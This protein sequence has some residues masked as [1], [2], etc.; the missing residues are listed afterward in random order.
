MSQT[1]PIGPNN[2]SGNINES[3][4]VGAFQKLNINRE[5]FLPIERCR[6]DGE[7]LT[8][9]KNANISDLKNQF[10]GV[11]I[12]VPD[13]QNI[14]RTKEQSVQNDL[15]SLIKSIQE[16]RKKP[17]T[18]GVVLSSEHLIGVDPGKT[19]RI[20][21]GVTIPVDGRFKINETEAARECY[22]QIIRAINKAGYREESVRQFEETKGFVGLCE[23]ANTVRLQNT[24]FKLPEKWWLAALFPLI[25]LPFCCNSCA[26]SGPDLKLFGQVVKDDF[27]I[28]LDKS[29]SM[30]RYFND[31]A[32]QAQ[33]LMNAKIKNGYNCSMDLITYDQGAKSVF[34]EITAIKGDHVGRLTAF[35]QN[36]KSGGG[37]NLKSGIDLATSEIIKHKKKT[38]LF[39]FTDGE[40]NSIAE[41]ISNAKDYKKKFNG[42]EVSINMTHPRLLGTTSAAVPNSD[43]EKQMDSLAKQFNG[44]FGPN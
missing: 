7:K 23:W 39:V 27:I 3:I 6:W 1:P 40:D 38:T 15:V 12:Q 35:L 28:V 13:P 44:R 17:E 21:F 20:R 29:S 30:E 43:F 19:T 36:L 22:S 37:T 26:C 24:S 9:G 10:V 31:V 41:I 42:I 4:I 8:L 16:L 25:F 34:G 14:D 2:S 18:S 32:N 5:L 11:R 33:A